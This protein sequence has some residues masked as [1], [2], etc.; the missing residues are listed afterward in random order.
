MQK[1]YEHFLSGSGGHA[2]DSQSSSSICFNSSVCGKDYRFGF[3]SYDRVSKEESPIILKE[4]LFTSY[5]LFLLNI[6]KE[7]K[8]ISPGKLGTLTHLVQCPQVFSFFI[9]ASSEVS[10]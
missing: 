4:G 8:D 10:H 9:L 3:L 2:A 5:D 6:I 1:A 7:S